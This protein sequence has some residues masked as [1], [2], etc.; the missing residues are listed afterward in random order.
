MSAYDEDVQKS[1]FKSKTNEAYLIKVL[2][3]LLTNN[4]KIG[5]FILDSTGIK[6]TQF[7][8]HRH[9]LVDMR[10]DSENF[11]VYRYKKSEK[12]Q[13]G[14]NLN[15]FHRMLKSI[16]KKDSL[17]LFISELDQNELGIKTIPKENNRVTTSGIKIQNIQNLDVILPEGYS[18]NPIIVSSS[19]FQ[20]MC[21]DLCNIGSPNI[22]VS[23]KVFNIEFTADADGIL[24]RKVILGETM[25]TDGEDIDLENENI[26]EATFSSEQFSRITKLAGLSSNLQIYTASQDMPLLFRS[27]IGSLGKISVYVKSNEMIENESKYNDDNSQNII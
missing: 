16:K 4:L 22:S 21:K 1:V 19:E 2:A 25:G 12:T 15:H 18:K 10:L 11:S 13:L 20:K 24:K 14:L 5:C 3:E 26:Y 7:D 23:A 27:N 9:T 17:Q 8:H 6:L